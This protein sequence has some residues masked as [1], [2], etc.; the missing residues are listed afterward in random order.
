MMN[1][2]WGNKCKCYCF[3]SGFKNGLVN[4]DPDRSKLYP[5]KGKN[6]EILCSN[7]VLAGL[8]AFS[9]SIDAL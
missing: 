2:L 9:W 6:G 8:E 1:Y 5:E 7:R 4:P 3:G